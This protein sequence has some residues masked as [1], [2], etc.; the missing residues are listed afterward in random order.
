MDSSKELAYAD[1]EWAIGIN[2]FTLEMIGL[3]PD[4]KLSN[5]QKF[6]ANLRAFVIFTTLI[7]VSIIPSIFSLVRVWNDMIA[8]ID[9]LQITL[10][11][12]ATAVKIIIMWLRKEGED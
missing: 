1:L 10:P 2:R 8:I 5:R 3:W 7:T 6:L 11:F 4:E 9:N 12:S